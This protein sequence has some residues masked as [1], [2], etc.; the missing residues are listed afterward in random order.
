MIETMTIE[1]RI[2]KRTDQEVL[3]EQIKKCT[4]VALKGSRGSGWASQIQKTIDVIYDEQGGV[5]A[6][7]ATIKFKTTSQRASLKDKWPRIV[8]RFAKAGCAGPFRSH[9]WKVISPTGYS[10]IAENAK[11]EGDRAVTIKI[12]AEQE[13]DLG[14]IN[15]E[16]GKH[17]ERLFGR[18]AQLRRIMDS[19]ILAK[20]TDFTHRV[21]TLLDG[22]P[23]CGKT[24]CMMSIRDMLGKEGEAW[25][26]LDAT[27]MT[28]AGVVEEL[29][30]APRVP[31]V[32]F[33]EEIEKT[34]ENSLRWLLGVMDIRGQIRRTNYR[35][36][37]QARN[38]KMVVI[39]SANDVQLL[40]SVM[41]GALYS[42]FQSRIYCPRPD[43]EI[44]K[45]ILEREVEKIN[46]N[47]KWIEPT[48]QFAF[49][50]WCMTDPRDV[51]TICACGGDRLLDGT[52]QK[53]YVATMHPMDRKALMKAKE[54]R[55]KSK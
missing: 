49:D 15:L 40:K 51:I 44:M 30:Q 38:V 39:A 21:N 22:P 20:R 5:W 35:V 27:S 18:E 2:K 28:K 48:L 36:G 34:D 46:G 26:W 32:L 50:E 42:R 13:K 1:R 16:P 11:A 43:R 45:K 47:T 33:V 19:L 9:P 8:E 54:D 10:E 23:G 41:S 55:A 17:F 14:E 24:E 6:H 7:T 53:D 52:Y 4:G 12:K 3:M 29:I 31:P 37:N 25:L